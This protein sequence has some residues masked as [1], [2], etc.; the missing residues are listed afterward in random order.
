MQS[1]TVTSIYQK[2]QMR[3]P[4][5]QAVFVIIFVLLFGWFVVMPK[6]SQVD[7]KSEQLASMEA[8]AKTL[9][10]DLEVV[11]K[12]VAEMETSK[13]EIKLVDEALPLTN[14]PTKIALLLEEFAKSSG[15]IVAQINVDNV[16]EN[17]ASGNKE[18]LNNPFDGNRVLTTTNVTVTVGG[19]LDQFKNF[20]TLLETSGRI[21]DVESFT[22]NSSEQD[23]RYNLKL[24]T[25]AYEIK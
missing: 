14:R 9:E 24:L 13:E 20:L 23:I 19:S 25:Y 4:V 1:P 15:M 3:N 18:E 6:N 8:Q 2:A 12:L 10:N 17:L 7:L 22:V 5:L 11:N 16:G 21:L